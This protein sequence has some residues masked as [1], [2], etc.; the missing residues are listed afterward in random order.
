MN[1]HDVWEQIHRSR[2]WGTY[3]SEHIIRFIARNYYNK[4]RAKIRIL[5]FGCGT[6]AHTWYLA[7]E[8]FDVYAFDISETAVRKLDDLLERENLHA[9]TSICDGLNLKYEN[10]LFDA[11][12]DNLSIQANQ[13]ADI[14]RMYHCVFRL[15]K[16]G[17]KFITVVFGRKTT[18]YGTGIEVEPGTY[19]NA[20]TGNIQKTGQRHFFEE[21]ELEKFLKDAG[22]INVTT[23]FSI[24]SDRGNIV[25]QYISIGEKP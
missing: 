3:P 25:S 10:G 4:D 2:D 16:S 14:E 9:H 23:D 21:E 7:R 5:D 22:F 24:Y 18:G 13:V 6:G 15:L 17:G 11:V 19:E 12:I 8:G 1:T 20:T